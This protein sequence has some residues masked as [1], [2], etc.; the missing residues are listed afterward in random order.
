M[1]PQFK[2]HFVEP[3]DTILRPFVITTA[4]A[5]AGGYPK[6]EWFLVIPD[7]NKSIF[8]QVT[9]FNARSFQDSPIV[10]DEA[11][12]LQEVYQQAELKLRQYVFEKYQARGLLEFFGTP[13]FIE[14]EAKA[15]VHY[16]L[17]GECQDQ[18]VRILQ[19]TECEPLRSYLD[20]IVGL[21]PIA[22]RDL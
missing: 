21:E 6:A 14:A 17:R 15:L 3:F 10:L 19:H 13:Y 11:F 8:C 18:L 12:M 22:R 5:N 2:F 7:E 16:W 1:Q 4:Y 9:R 20:S